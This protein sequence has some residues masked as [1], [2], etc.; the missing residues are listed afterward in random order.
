MNMGRNRMITPTKVRLALLTSGWLLSVP[1]ALA[2]G[3]HD[4]GA[5]AHGSHEEADVAPI[6]YT[7]YSDLTELFVEFPPLQA[8]MPSRLAAHVTRLADFK[9]L[10]KGVMEVEFLR[11]DV[12]QAGFR[13]REP[14]R[15]GIFSPTVT[16]KTAGTYDMLVRVR[17]DDRV[18]VH[19]LGSVQVSSTDEPRPPGQQGD[20]G[21]IRYLK[22][23]QWQSPFRSAPLQRQALRASAPGF[24]TVVAPADGSAMIR[25]PSDGYFST[26]RLLTAGDSVK[27][28]SVLGYI[29]PRLGDGSDIG[30]LTL[31]VERARARLELARRDSERLDTLLKKGA[32]SER[33][34]EEAGQALDIAVVELS[35]AESRLQL[36]SGK[37]EQAG[38]VLNAPMGGVVVTANVRPGAF[39]RADT[40]LFEVVDSQ[41]RW[42]DIQVP[43]K[44]SAAIPLTQGVWLDSATPGT[45]PTLIDDSTGARVISIAGVIDP[46]TRTATVTVEYPAALI[47]TPLGARFSAHVLYG[48]SRKVLA[49]PRGAVIDDGGRPVVFVQTG[50][51]SFSR[52]TVTLGI[53]DST[54]IEVLSGVQEGE[55][56]V[57]EG[58][59]YVKLAAAGGE[60][61]G[62]GH[63]H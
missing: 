54:W 38:L 35:T 43:E 6:V 49:L 25:A 22:E 61:I 51:E 27:R 48:E 28:D 18:S 62:H 13:V 53:Q 7:H 2:G 24:A 39:V 32:V 47:P 12:L 59:Y 11:D 55:R 10:S 19:H 42:L 40:I 44:F 30:T 41:R 14:A 50:G 52:R 60:E 31:D 57:S 46:A 1:F 56:V 58:A 34:V 15:L 45:P 36:R 3:G 63:A 5:E 21:D 33:R 26:T 23:Q 37:R 8:G 4:H 20:T 9:P 17:E 16:L 29:V